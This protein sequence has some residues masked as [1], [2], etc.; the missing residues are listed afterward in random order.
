MTWPLKLLMAGV[1]IVFYVDGFVIGSSTWMILGFSLLGLLVLAGFHRHAEHGPAEA[2]APVP[3]L[4]AALAALAVAV[5]SRGAG[6]SVVLATALVGVAG[7]SLDRLGRSLGSSLPVAAPIYCGAFAGMT[8]QR[9]LLHPG[10]VLLAGAL[11]GV[12]L[13]LLHN[14]WGGVGGKL[15]TTAFLAVLGSCALAYSIGA[16]GPGEHLH[17]MTLSEHLAIT[18]IA[19]LAPLITH[20]ISYRRGMGAVLGS[21]LPSLLMALVLPPPLAASWLGGSFV[22][23][24][25]PPLLAPH[26]RAMLLAMGLVFALLS[27]SFEPSLAGIGGDLGATAAVSVLAVLGARTA[28]PRLWRTT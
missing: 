1:L 7:D 15:G 9:L 4:A 16:V 18:L 14:S 25:A 23:M 5:L 8:S 27:Q 10:W 3:V 22:G 2:L 13:R 21:A 6:L 28:F 19:V 20:R 11:A 12:L 26:P 17:P 24:T